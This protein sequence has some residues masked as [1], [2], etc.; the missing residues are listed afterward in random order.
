MYQVKLYNALGVV[1]CHG[2][3]IQGIPGSYPKHSTITSIIKPRNH[4]Y[5]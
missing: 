2:I 4:E 1:S 5:S 3:Y